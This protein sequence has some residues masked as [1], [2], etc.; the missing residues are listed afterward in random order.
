VKILKAVGS[1]LSGIPLESCLELILRGLDFAATG[2]GDDILDL[3]DNDFHLGSFKLGQGNLIL[4]Q[5]L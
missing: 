1:H 3:K 4:S 2:S 5:D